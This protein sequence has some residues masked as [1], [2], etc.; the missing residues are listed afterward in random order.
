MNDFNVLYG[1][2]MFIIPCSNKYHTLFLKSQYLI[3]VIQH[4]HTDLKTGEDS[5]R[6]IIIQN[7]SLY[8]PYGFHVFVSL[9]V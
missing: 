3:H 5:T 7:S 1:N 4:V 9:F 2:K 6:E 8:N